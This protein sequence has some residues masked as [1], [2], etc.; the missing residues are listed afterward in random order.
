MHQTGFTTTFGPN[1]VV[2]IAGSSGDPPLSAPDGDYTSCR[3]DKPC[4][5]FT[6]AAVTSRSW[7]AGVVQAQLMDGSVHA[8]DQ[9]IE[10]QTWRD[11]GSRD[12]N[13]PPGG[14]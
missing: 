4:N 7:H 13:N 10:L 2:P 9:T 14:F 3:E 11:L 12:D 6:R 5:T 1:T 8:I